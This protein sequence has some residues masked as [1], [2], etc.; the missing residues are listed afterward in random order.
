MFQD[1]FQDLLHGRLLLLLP[2][3]AAGRSW[4]T[5]A[6]PTGEKAQILAKASGEA[7]APGV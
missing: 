4:G 2:W 5:E 6:F 1:P 3:A 7:A